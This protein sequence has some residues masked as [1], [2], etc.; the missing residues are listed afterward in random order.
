MDTTFWKARVGQMEAMQDYEKWVCDHEDAYPMWSRRIG[1]LDAASGV[2]LPELARRC[3]ASERTVRRWM[4]EIPAKRDYVICLACALGLSLEE[5]NS[6]LRRYAKTAQLYVKNPD[7]SI[8]E[9]ILWHC[10]FSVPLPERHEHFR[11]VYIDLCRES[12]EAED[13]PAAPAA[14]GADAGEDGEDTYT[15][16]QELRREVLDDS[17]FRSFMR[18]ELPNYRERYGK[19]IAYIRAWIGDNSLALLAREHMTPQAQVTPAQFDKPLSEI[20]SAGYGRGRCRL[21]IPSRSY[22]IALGIHLSMPVD[23]IDEMLGLAGMEGLCPKDRLEGAIIFALEDLLLN[24]PEV[25]GGL[26]DDEVVDGLADGRGRGAETGGYTGLYAD[27]KERQKKLRD[28]EA[29]KKALDSAM[30]H[31]RGLMETASA[32]KGYPDRKK[33]K[34]PVDDEAWMKLMDGAL[35]EDISRFFREDG[36]DGVEFEPASVADYLKKRISTSGL[37]EELKSSSLMRYL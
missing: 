18:R 8:W 17:A 25:F 27:T 5:T 14:S 9:Y 19:L 4:K 34:R 35:S 28:H 3:G 10:D 2:P 33:L 26:I 21:D 16:T 12:D 11:Q 31:E 15:M 24:A 29:W 22:L 36:E 32:K 1:E 7:D 13:G 20:R 30:A 23:N 6:L 37:A